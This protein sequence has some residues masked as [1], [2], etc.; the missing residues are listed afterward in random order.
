MGSNYRHENDHHEKN[1]QRDVIDDDDV[2]LISR[3]DR[4]KTFYLGRFFFTLHAKCKDLCNPMN[5][6]NSWCIIRTKV[7]PHTKGGRSDVVGHT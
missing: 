7:E 6:P 3:Y 4:E 1:D 2:G 5:G